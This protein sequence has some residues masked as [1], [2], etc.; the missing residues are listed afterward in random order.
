MNLQMVRPGVLRRGDESDGLR[1]QRVA[2]VDD[3]IAV[4]EH[5]ADERVPLVQDNLHAVGPAALVAARQETD[6]G[7]GGTCGRTH[8]TNS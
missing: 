1:V 4:A 2:H 7:C 8:H 3:R 5:V 6:V